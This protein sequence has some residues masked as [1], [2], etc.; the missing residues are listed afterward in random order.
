MSDFPLNLDV[1]SGGGRAPDSGSFHV[2]FRSGSRATGACA[3]SAYDYIAREGQFDNAELDRA[4]YVESGNMPSWAEADPREYWDASD[5]YERA[6][7]LLLAVTS[8]CRA[9]STSKTRS[10]WRAPSSET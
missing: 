7:G 3:A 10:T 6:N 2:S 8:H 1:T 9:G 4:V 5:L